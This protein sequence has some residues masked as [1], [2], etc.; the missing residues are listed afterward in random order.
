MRGL[1]KDC[2]M[3]I[4]D[5]LQPSIQQLTW[6]SPRDDIHNFLLKVRINC[7]V[8]EALILH[9]ES[10][11][12]KVSAICHDISISSLILLEKKRVYEISEF[13]GI[14][15]K[16]QTT[17]C[18]KFERAFVSLKDMVATS[19]SK[20]ASDTED[21]YVAWDKYCER[22]W[23]WRVHYV[24]QPCDLSQSSQRWSAPKP[25]LSTHYSKHCLCW[26]N[27]ATM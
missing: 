2:V 4:N 21:I 8:I 1:M 22:K 13:E 18:E 15:T 5:A 9:V 6:M 27:Q 16:Y 26:I 11:S 24:K 7:S 20:C 25:K 3:Q 10:S 14:Q 12:Q 19:Y 23:N 17:M